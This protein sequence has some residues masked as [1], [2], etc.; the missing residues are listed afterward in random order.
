MGGS[1]VEELDGPAKNKRL[2]AHRDLTQYTTYGRY[3][4]WHNKTPTAIRESAL[5]NV[6]ECLIIV[7]GG[8]Y[9]TPIRSF[10]TS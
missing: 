4:E 9:R 6:P 5:S 8:W 2:P 3:R 1:L 7:S 10:E